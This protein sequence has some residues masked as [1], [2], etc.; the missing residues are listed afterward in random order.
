MVLVTR[1]RAPPRAMGWAWARADLQP[2]PHSLDSKRHVGRIK[3]KHRL[4]IVFPLLFLSF[5]H[6]LMFC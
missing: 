6:V 3:E 5:Q 1:D 4:E 2:Q